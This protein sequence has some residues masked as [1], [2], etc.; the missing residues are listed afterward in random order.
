VAEFRGLMQYG[1][2][3]FETLRSALAA[4]AFLPVFWGRAMTILNFRRFA[5]P[6]CAQ[7]RRHNTENL[8]L[9]VIFTVSRK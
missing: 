3:R 1:L 7:I 5:A 4:Q 8:A 9:I 6:N 2:P